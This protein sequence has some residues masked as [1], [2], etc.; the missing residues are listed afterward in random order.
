M[1]PDDEIELGTD[2]CWLVVYDSDL[3]MK[4][5]EGKESLMALLQDLGPE[6]VTS[7]RRWKQGEL[8]S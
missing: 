2:F 4:G 1:I 3:C 8:F 5:G 6:R 7:V